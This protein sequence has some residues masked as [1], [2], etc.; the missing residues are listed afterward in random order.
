MRQY[1]FEKA[2]CGV[3][4]QKQRYIRLAMGNGSS[5]S[6]III[7]RGV[8]MIGRRSRMEK[9]ENMVDQPKRKRHKKQPE[10]PKRLEEKTINAMGEIFPGFDTWY[11]ANYD[12]QGKMLPSTKVPGLRPSHDEIDP[13][14]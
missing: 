12:E 5:L 10:P 14:E 2:S 11:R 6:T 8:L 1:S 3:A 9:V 7:L 4:L 13:G